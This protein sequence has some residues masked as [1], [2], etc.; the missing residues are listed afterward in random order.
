M[1]N[2]YKILVGNPEGET[3]LGRPTH[4]WQ[5]IRMCFRETGWEVVEWIILARDRDQ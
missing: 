4:K 5:D 1:R 3:P 2:A